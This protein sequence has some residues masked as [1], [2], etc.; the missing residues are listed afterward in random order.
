MI[1]GT[2]HGPMGEHL[3]DISFTSLGLVAH[4]A[5]PR[6][7]HLEL[8]IEANVQAFFIGHIEAL[9]TMANG[10]D[11]PP[12]GRVVDTEC[13]ELFQTLQ[14]GDA[15][16]FAGAASVL[17]KRLIGHMNRRT[18]RGLLACVR[19]EDGPDR[20]TAVLKLEIDSS[21]GTRLEELA[22]GELRLAAVTNVLEQPGDLQK[23]VLGSSRMP[24]EEVLCGD[25]HTR[26]ARYFPEALG[27]RAYARPSQGP[28]ELLKAVQQ[29][30]TAL[31]AQVAAA[32]PEVR[33]GTISDV[34]AAIAER[35]P[36]FEADAWSGLAET[37]RQS[38]RPIV[39][40]DT[41]KRV[42]AVIEGDDL[43]IKAPA[44][45]L[46]ERVELH[47]TE[48]GWEARVRFDRKPRTTYR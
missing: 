33:S 22:S 20:L 48:N 16:E 17:A 30:D 24:A 32:L 36:A 15:D 12:P 29:Q 8:N 41:T 13:Q 19:A 11:A 34:I 10:P 4:D 9:Q 39:N 1:S 44:E 6:A 27:I 25:I 47:E 26:H 23:G 3:L 46:G 18:A 7:A 45:D 14:M 38:P 28:S 42:T 31:A 5:E 35:V 40:V 21:N 37:L 43:T 2:G